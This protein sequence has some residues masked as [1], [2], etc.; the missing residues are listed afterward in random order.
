M[1]LTENDLLDLT[2][3]ELYEHLRRDP[4]RRGGREGARRVEARTRLRHRRL[5]RPDARLE[6]KVFDRERGEL[7]SRISPLR[8][9]GRAR[10]GLQGREL[11][12]PEGDDRARLLEDVPDRARACATRSGRLRQGSTSA[13]CSR[14]SASCSTSRW[15]SSNEP[16]PARRCL[17]R[18]SDGRRRQAP[19]RRHGLPQLARL[20]GLRPDLRADRPRARLGQGLAA[21]RAR[22]LIGV[23]N[24]LRRHNLHDTNVA[25]T[26]DAKPVPPFA[27]VAAHV[28][29]A[30]R[31]LQRPRRPGDGPRRR[32]LRPQRPHRAHLPEAR[33][34]AAGAEPAPRQPRAADA[35]PVRAGDL[36]ER[37]RRGVAAV[38]D[39]RLVQPRARRRQPDVDGPARGR[40]PVARE[41]DGDPE[42]PADPTRPPGSDDFPPTYVNT[43]SH[44]W[45]ASQLYGSSLEQQKL[46][47][48]GVDGKLHIRDDG[49]LPTPPDPQ[50]DPSQVP[51][52]WL[53]IG[54]MQVDLHP[55]AQ[56]DLRPAARRVPVVDGRRDLRA[57]AAD[58]RGA[59]REDPHRRVDAGRDQPPDDGDRR[60]ASTGG[61]SPARSCTTCSAA[62]RR[63]R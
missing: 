45:D 52:F 10:E 12:R 34:G 37:A 1:P 25:P 48:S 30:G 43:E 53:G 47:R 15:R 62:S 60:C 55:R 4:G 5:G 24:E 18:D 19:R 7:R 21:A 32:A 61:A 9:P 17:A 36:G 3:D 42:V 28:A 40:R 44:W 16:A 58:Q 20:A 23:R 26:V 63:A 29:L 35:R 33:A 50:H 14:G 49:L 59:D 41:A 11:V 6:G 8:L 51:G 54:L 38:H 22:A 46:L 56:R 31:H 39:P 2:S 13:W 57:R 27:R